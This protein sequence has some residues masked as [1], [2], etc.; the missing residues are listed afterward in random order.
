MFITDTRVSSV[1]VQLLSSYIIGTDA[2]VVCTI[3]LTNPIGLDISSLVVNWFK[4]DD[5]ITDNIA[6]SGS[7]S[8]FDSILTLTQVSLTDAGVYTCNASIIGSD[9][10]IKDSN[11]LCLKGTGIYV[12]IYILLILTYNSSI[13]PQPCKFY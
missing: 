10:V 4:N 13:L 3:S 9:E 5:M 1:T 12:S 6:I 7:L 2:L 8:T 11:V